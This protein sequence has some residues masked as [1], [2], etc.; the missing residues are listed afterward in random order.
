[1]KAFDAECARCNQVH[2]IWVGYN[3]QPGDVIDIAHDNCGYHEHLLVAELS[4]LDHL[5]RWGPEFDHQE[6]DA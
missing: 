1:M 3:Q 5:D 4:G 6:A 2:V